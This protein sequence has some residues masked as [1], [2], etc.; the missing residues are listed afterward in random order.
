MKSGLYIIAT[1]IGNLEDITFRAVE[2]LKNLDVI[3]CEDTRT[4]Q[5]LCSR[6]G[7]K[8]KTIS[9]HNYNVAAMIPKI[10]S[11][12]EQGEAV[13]LVSDAGTPIIS[14][15]G[16]K[17]VKTLLEKK[18]Y[19]TTIP[20]AS[21]VTSA[22]TLS[23]IASDRFMFAGFLPNK[24]AARCTLLNELKN[25]PATL[26]FFESPNR[27]LA[28]LIDIAK[29]LGNREVSVVREITKIYEEVNKNKVDSLIEYY[30]NKETPKGE[31]VIVIERAAAEEANLDEV[32]VFLNQCLNNQISIKDAAQMASETFNISK[33]EAYHIALKVKG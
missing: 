19:V 31:I 10:I 12:I 28:S 14:D 18:L 11:R 21:A 29:I 30:Q 1:P 27:L 32:E 9:Y 26:I 20:G 33:K 3:A 22:L 15:P 4:T 24:T 7:I 17:L 23:G 16:F 2:T 8:T 6:Y 25:I 13:G 5:K